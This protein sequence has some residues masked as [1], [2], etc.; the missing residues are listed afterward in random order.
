MFTEATLRKLW[1]HGD[2]KIPGL[3]AGIAAAAPMVFQKYGFTTPTVVAQAMA[4]F[5]H[6][7][8]AG[9][10]VVENLNYSASGLQKTW[11]SRFSASKAAMYAHNPRKIANEVYNGRMENR[12]GSDDGWNF[13][14]RGGSQVTG[15]EGYTKL[16][17]EIGLDLPASPDKVNDPAIFLEAAVA[18]FVLC[19]CLPYAERDDVV[20]VT[21]KLNG[22]Q[23][24]IGMRRAWLV[25]WKTAMADE[26]Q[27]VPTAVPAP[28]QDALGEFEVKGIQQRLIDLGYHEVGAVD[29][30]WGGRTTGAIAAFQKDNGLPITGNYDDATKGALMA[31]TANER[32]IA[33]ARRNATPAD[34][35][36]A[37][38]TTVRQAQSGSLLGWLKMVLGG[39]FAGGG[40]I[41]QNTDLLKGAQDTV[42]KL[43]QVKSIGDSV[44]DL[45]HGAFSHPMVIVLGL[46]L[47]FGG[48][49]IHLISTAIIAQRLQDHQDGVHP[50]PA[51]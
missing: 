39:L 38:S 25:K 9:L 37:G 28:P 10:E 32:P 45:A 40:A 36:K 11:P 21:Q 44:R 49:A 20:G 14:G 30:N 42:D 46:V 7:C 31:A 50:G 13:R 16:G 8:G 5:S 2:D 17:A 34:L 1:P 23:I 48:Y 3:V 22:G 51:S 43:N 41:D 4:Q 19:G 26:G 12:T 6:E 47:L 27:N 18:D 29:G 24:G 35:A 15:R 33:E